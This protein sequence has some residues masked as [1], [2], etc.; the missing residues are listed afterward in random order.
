MDG[1]KGNLSF[2]IDDSDNFAVGQRCL[3]VLI[4]NVAL[5]F[6]DWLSQCP[7]FISH[8]RQMTAAAYAQA[9]LAPGS[10]HK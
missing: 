1:G 6:C 10:I 2:L 7:V 8:Y 5:A 9:V 4:I 3:V